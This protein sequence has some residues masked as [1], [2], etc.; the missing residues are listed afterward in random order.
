[1]W[2]LYCEGNIGGIKT[3]EKCCTCGS[4]VRVEGKTTKYYVP[5]ENEFKTPKEI[6]SGEDMK[7]DIFILGGYLV[8]LGWTNKVMPSE[9]V[10][11][12]CQAFLNKHCGGLKI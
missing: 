6:L 1:V 5:V 3:I 11:E 2:G 7:T 9:H 8:S 12:V 10:I 4:P